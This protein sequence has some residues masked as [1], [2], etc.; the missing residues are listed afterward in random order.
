MKLENDFTNIFSENPLFAVLL[1]GHTF[2][3]HWEKMVDVMHLLMSSE[4]SGFYS[5]AYCEI[6]HALFVVF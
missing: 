1:N 5:F 6:L 3:V 2:M 4:F